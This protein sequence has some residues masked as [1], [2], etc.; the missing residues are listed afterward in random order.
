MKTSKRTP[1]E[2]DVAFI[3]GLKKAQATGEVM[4]A[5]GINICPPTNS[6]KNWRIKKSYKGTPIE[7]SGGLTAAETYAAYLEVKAILESKNLGEQGLPELSNVFL[8]EVLE[9]YLN[10]G[11]KDYRWK[12]KT[13][14]LRKQDLNHLIAL[15]NEQKLLCSQLRAS[16]LRD[17]LKRATKTQ[18]RAKHLKNILRTFM[19]WGQTAG[20]FTDQQA[21]YVDQIAW[22][23]PA[24]S[25]YQAAPNRRRQSQLKFGTT[26]HEGGQVPT[27]EQVIALANEVQKRYVH[28]YGFVLVSC[29]MGSRANETLIYT[30]DRAVHD[31][32]LG[33]YVDCDE[34]VVLDHWQYAEEADKKHRT[35]KTGKMRAIVI[36]PVQV[37][38]SGFDVREFLKI[39]SV[40]ALREQAAGKN[41]LALIFPSPT[42]KV[43]NLTSFGER[44]IRPAC[45]SLG[46]KMGYEDADG[47]VLGMYR[48]TIHSLRDRY[49]TTAAQEWGYSDIQ[50]LEQ[51]GWSDLQTVRKYYIGT[52]D[53]TYKTVK[54]LHKELAK[55]KIPVSK[56]TLHKNRVV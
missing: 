27:H 20:Y 31:A 11:G 6:R 12:P 10:Q 48:F 51:G 4:V 46:W 36:P 47:K 15:C 53:D 54:D 40:E 52:T 39:R 13:R 55:T 38:A 49:G 37:I 17:Y 32:G 16:H 43:I 28:G 2:P 24:G 50:L 34:W 35:T 3:K 23:P 26:E 18:G 5:D 56:Q 44:T 9:A 25:A 8:A 29:N 22:T 21:R 42:G 33:N 19:D 45:E 30:A 1:I 41:P 7:R 14:R